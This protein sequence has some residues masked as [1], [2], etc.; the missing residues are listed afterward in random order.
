VTVGATVATGLSE[1]RGAT[2]AGWDIPLKEEGF[3]RRM[4]S[5]ISTKLVIAIVAALVLAVAAVGA[6]RGSSRHVVGHHRNRVCGLDAYW[7]QASTEGDIF[8]IRGGRIAL[9]KSSNTKVRF[10]ARILVKDHTK[11]LKETR[12]LAHELGVDV[13][14]EP[15]PTEKWQLEE[16]AELRGSNFNHDYSELEVA[17]HIQDIQDAMDEVEMGCNTHVRLLAKQDIP[18]L[19]YHLKLARKALAASGPEQHSRS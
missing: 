4:V 5:S 12:A 16:I 6:A 10:L 9:V 7:L 17:D 11:S 18:L 19:R 3:M 13:P 1:R 8:E 15:S 2:L 14:N